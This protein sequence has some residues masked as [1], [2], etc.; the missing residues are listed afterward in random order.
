MLDRRSF[1]K[2][3]AGAGAALA[4]GG[5][6]HTYRAQLVR[7]QLSLAALR[8]PLQLALL[9]DLHAGP[10]VPRSLIARWVQLA[11]SAAPEVIVLAGDL[12]DRLFIGDPAPIVATLAELRAP[13]GVYA[14]WG[15]HEYLRFRERPARARL[16]D[17]LAE[18][19]IRLLANEG[20][21]LRD[22]LYLAGLDDIRFGRA[23][24]A[25]ALR[26][27]PA[28]AA[29]IVVVHNPD[30]IPRLPPVEL[31]LCGHTHGG[32]IVLPGVGPLVTSSAYGRRF[33]QGW[34]S[35][36]MPAYVTRGLG[37]TGLPLRLNCP[38]EL[39]LFELL[40]G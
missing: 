15:N 40:P 3:L 20:V 35:A 36:P 16:R 23:D 1:L 5:G 11:Q 38:P 7:Q 13:L 31:V 26:G 32:Q 25:L 6:L 28:G 33:A 22:D 10:Y 18:T 27:K 17:A 2:A 37:V 14:V 9:S 12:F 4:L 34:V 19:G 24:A 39:T 29:G 30:A 21:L 8:Q